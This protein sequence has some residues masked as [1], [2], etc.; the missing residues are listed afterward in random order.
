MQSLQSTKGARKRVENQRGTSLVEVCI[1]MVV[2]MVAV[3]GLAQL[4]SYS[5]SNNT[6]GAD[7]AMALAIAQ[8]HLE[9]LRDLPFDD[10][11]LL[12][13]TVAGTVEMINSNGRP[14]T[15]V[16]IIVNATPTLK[17]ITIRVTP[18]GSSAAWART[19]VVITTQRSALST[20]ANLS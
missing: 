13:T 9:S 11:K 15:V 20:G 3:L 6:G 16:T 17:T 18:R 8:Q 14:F 5:I 7:R 12:A 4:F 19:F 1:A 10:T 2:M